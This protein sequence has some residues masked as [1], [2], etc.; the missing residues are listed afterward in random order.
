MR[1]Q[2]RSVPAA[3]GSG[4]AA[5]AAPLPALPAQLGLAG[6]LALPP[7]AAPALCPGSSA[8]RRFLIGKAG[9][10]DGD[11]FNGSSTGSNLNSVSYSGCW[12]GH[13]VLLTLSSA[14]FGVTAST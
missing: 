5:A 4:R 11:V 2:S 6:S 12:K 8:A 7:C 10:N 14:A 13:L 9:R 1:A 3:I